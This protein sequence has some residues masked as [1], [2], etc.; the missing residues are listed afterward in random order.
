MAEIW[1]WQDQDDYDDWLNEL[2]K[3]AGDSYDDDVAM[4]A[5]TTVYVHDLAES[6]QWLL[7]KMSVAET[8]DGYRVALPL[9]AKG[10]HDA[11]G[12]MRRLLRDYLDQLHA[13]RG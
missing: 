4:E 13:V 12:C 2:V 7:D 5:I 3:H 8:D 10:F 11:P 9:S 6:V 1:Q